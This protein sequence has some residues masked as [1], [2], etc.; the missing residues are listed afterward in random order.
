MSI[1][2]DSMIGK[3]R[4]AL[5]YCCKKPD[6]FVPALDFIV[7]ATTGHILPFS[8]EDECVSAELIKRLDHN[9]L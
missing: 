5:G 8:E 7:D 1:K 9:H 4:V 2:S 6:N 3:K